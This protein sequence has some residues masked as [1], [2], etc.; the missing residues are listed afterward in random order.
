[1]NPSRISIPEPCNENWN[2]M[3]PNEK[4]RF[5]DLCSKTVVDFTNKTEE[6]I[7][8]II[9]KNTDS[10]ICGRIS[11]TSPLSISISI[12]QSVL[13]KKHS[14]HKAFLLAL[15]ICM[16]TTLFSCKDLHNTS[17]TIGEISIVD[18]STTLSYSNTVSKEIKTD[19]LEKKKLN[20]KTAVPSISPPPRP[21]LGV[22][23]MGDIVV[24]DS[25]PSCAPN[26]EILP[27]KIYKLFE[28]TQKPEFPGGDSEFRKYILKNLTLPD[29]IT[30]SLIFVEF[31]INKKGEIE[32]LEIIRSKYP[33]LNE[34]LTQIIK[35]TPLWEPGKINQQAVSV[36]IIYPIQ[37]LIK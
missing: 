15:L 30:R 32:S 37:I 26:K 11:I 23:A 16:G 6:Q 10:K 25:V 14:F 13:K 17:H 22:I 5:C 35:N 20:K 4:G 9:S 29:S 7:L 8:S 1:M 18:D 34:P 31:I 12:P 3:T 33:E 21:T 2:Q 27:D 24:K 28:V 19:T 36:K